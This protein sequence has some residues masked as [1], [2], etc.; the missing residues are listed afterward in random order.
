MRNEPQ[1]GSDAQ[2]S[3][4]FEIVNSMPSMFHDW[5]ESHIHVPIAHHLHAPPGTAILQDQVGESYR[6]AV[7]YFKSMGIDVDRMSSACPPTGQTFTTNYRTDLRWLSI[8]QQQIRP[9]L[10]MGGHEDSI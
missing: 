4:N 3:A 9:V 8:K 6:S 1:M 5:N 7:Q 10:G 2:S